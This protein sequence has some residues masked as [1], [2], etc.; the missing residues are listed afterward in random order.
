MMK[1]P[2]AGGW[3]EGSGQAP[4]GRRQ[5]LITQGCR[6]CASQGMWSE[7]SRTPRVGLG[8]GQC[9]AARVK[10]SVWAEV[11]RSLHLEATP[12]AWLSPSGCPSPLSHAA[13]APDAAALLETLTLPPLFPISGLWPFQRDRL[14]RPLHRRV[15][16]VLCLI[17]QIHRRISSQNQTRNGVT[18][19]ENCACQSRAQEG[20]EA[21]LRSGAAPRGPQGEGA[22]RGGEGTRDHQPALG[23]PAGQSSFADRS[24]NTGLWFL[25]LLE[26]SRQ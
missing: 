11:C 13:T 7:G 17:G 8:P 22:A 20:G 16:A 10:G 4:L 24:C 6:S 2:Q 12:E 25:L 5:G 26:V 1:H 9:K 15:P 18:L 23:L 19:T 3:R 14:H 21:L